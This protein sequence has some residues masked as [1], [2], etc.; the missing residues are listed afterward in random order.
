MFGKK[1]VA[2][3]IA[4]LKKIVEELL[5]VQERELKKADDKIVEIRRMEDEVDAHQEEALAAEKQAKKI[6]DI[7]NL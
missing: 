3:I 4:P 1:T 7:L 6:E 5:E 2:S